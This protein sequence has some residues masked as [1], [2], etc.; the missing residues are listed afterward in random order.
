MLVLTLVV[1]C[2]RKDVEVH[3]FILVGL[4]GSVATAQIYVKE[5]VWV[6]VMLLANLH[7]QEVIL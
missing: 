5:V 4:L 3:A 7:L 1:R 2:V 6:V